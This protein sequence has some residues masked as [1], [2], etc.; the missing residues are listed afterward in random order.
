M[1]FD[2]SITALFAYASVSPF[3]GTFIWTGVALHEI[4]QTFRRR[5]NGDIVHI[6]ISPEQKAK[7]QEASMRLL[8]RYFLQPQ[9]N[10]DSAPMRKAL[11]T[12]G[13]A[14]FA[15][16]TLWHAILERPALNFASLQRFF[17][18]IN[19]LY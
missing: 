8:D 19:R 9:G 15:T 1:G 17:W 18:K 2:F 7:R 11:C 13:V 10:N 4:Y 12:I 6:P 3:G 16:A 5:R 14:A